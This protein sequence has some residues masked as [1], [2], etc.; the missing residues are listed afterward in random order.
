M[1][2]KYGLSLGN[3]LMTAG[4]DAFVE[5]LGSRLDADDH[6]EVRLHL[7]AFGGPQATAEWARV[8]SAR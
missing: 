6:G 8:R 5:E 1:A 7:F 3:L 4:P 2:R